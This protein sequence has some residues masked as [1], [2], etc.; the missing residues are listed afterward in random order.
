[1][2]F[3]LIVFCVFLYSIIIAAIYYGGSENTYSDSK[4]LANYRNN[5]KIINELEYSNRLAARAN[6]LAS[7]DIRNKMS[8]LYETNK[9]N[10]YRK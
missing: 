1:M 10:D 8:G 6:E 5:S 9:R 3:F 2:D 4:D 7:T